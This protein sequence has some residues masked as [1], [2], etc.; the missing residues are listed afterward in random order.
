MTSIAGV[1]AA[2]RRLHRHRPPL[3]S[4]DRTQP[5]L[6]ASSPHGHRNLLFSD[7]RYCLFS[8]DTCRLLQHPLSVA[9]SHSSPERRVLLHADRRH[10]PPSSSSATHA[11]LLLRRRHTPS[12]TVPATH[13]ATPAP[14]THTPLTASGRAGTHDPLP[15]R[16]HWRSRTGRHTA[17]RPRLTAASTLLAA[18]SHRCLA[19]STHRWPVRVPHP[20]RASR[21]RHVAALQAASRRRSRRAP[22]LWRLCLRPRAATGDSQH[23]APAP[24]SVLQC[25]PRLCWPPRRR[26]PPL[27]S[28]KL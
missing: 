11:E 20:R 5:S 25:S 4:P 1:A 8:S 19:G 7:T 23:V 28:T 3:R 16:H 13:A 24:C 15:Q 6:H 10:A 18:P 21:A 14:A 22:R 2:R 27:F 9:M 12:S 26:P 17:G